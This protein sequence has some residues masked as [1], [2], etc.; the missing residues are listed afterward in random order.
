MAT[1]STTS[2]SVA[3]VLR[4]DAEALAQAR[5]LAA[6]FAV[7]AADRDRDRRIP[8]AEL[9][10]LSASG[11][12]AATVPA[13][14]GGADITTRTL[15]EVFRLLASAD[16]SIAQIPQ[17]HFAYVNVLRESATPEQEQ[18]FFA[19]LL[20]GKRFGNAQSE[21]GSRT[22][23]DVQTRLQDTG[24]GD[25]VLNG[26]KGY[27]TGALLAHW[28]PMLAKD[29][30][31]RLQVA[32][33]P[34][35]AEGVEVIDDWAGMGQR[36]TASGTVVLDR[37]RVPA[38]RI[39]P[40]HL[41]FERPQLHGALAQALH[42][43][44]D[45]GIAAGALDEAAE[46]VRTRSRPWGEAGVDTAAED[47]LTIQRFG[48]LGIRLRAAEALLDEAGAAIDAA[49]ADLTDESAGAASIAVAA[50]KAFADGTAIELTNALFE[51]SGAR[52][53]LDSANLHRHWRNARTHTLHDPVRWKV[54]H[55][56]RYTL[57][58]T[59][60]PRHGQI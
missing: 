14:H 32:Y 8:H 35:D 10:E 12:L 43:A 29:D 25:F 23:Q 17:S 24:E 53:S 37:V 41:T 55:V 34:R 30:E 56:G 40:H 39:V 60:P 47:P 3:A 16:P 13:A 54:H 28:I 22:V 26:R 51:V 15:L 6:S 1:T 59:L 33:V 31:D 52:S 44:I 48:D 57:N 9:D 19:E 27:S 21:T 58:G 45:V 2:T 18:F 49:R 50:A 36:T 7:E 20:A 4:D 38:D 46:F 42:A 11:L 5:R